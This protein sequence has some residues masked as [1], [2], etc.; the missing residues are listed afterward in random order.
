M[1]EDNRR[2][3]VLVKVLTVNCA[4]G[5]PRD[6]RKPDKLGG[7]IADQEIDFVFFQELAELEYDDGPAEQVLEEILEVTRRKAGS[8]YV[9]FFVPAVDTTRHPAPEWVPGSEPP[10]RGKWYAPRF[11]GSG[12]SP[13]Y[14]AQGNGF[15]VD[16]NKWEVLDLWG[17]P[18][19]GSAA[20][21][22]ISTASPFLGDRE[23]EPRVL[24]LL[25][26]RN[27][28]SGKELC[29]ATTH[30]TVL[31]PE[32]ENRGGAS[33][34]KAQVENICHVFGQLP[35]GLDGIILGGDLNA[36]LSADEL[37]PLADAGFTAATSE[38]SPKDMKS[39][40]HQKK[41][42]FIDHFFYSKNSGLSVR[43]C[44]LPTEI[45]DVSDHRP[46]LCSFWLAG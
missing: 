7:Y 31:R 35:D 9:G 22:V 38:C 41:K 45:E 14:A 46:V 12:R 39:G 29:L 36:I 6:E 30:L 4:G 3:A 8:T 1:M 17:G 25:R 40:T 16:H 44:G 10:R 24:A 19:S 23:S 21:V 5:K 33:V 18:R 13:R 27:R 26:V 20:A 42:I 34:R 43:D 11:I 28:E 15:L 2:T 32:N 37:R